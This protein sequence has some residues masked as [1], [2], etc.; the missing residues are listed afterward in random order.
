MAVKLKNNASSKLAGAIS[1]AATTITVVTGEGGKFPSL[2]AGDYFP[3]TLVKLVAGAPVYEIAYCTAIAGDV[4]TIAR[5]KEGTL[6]TTFSAG[7]A[8]ELRMTSGVFDEL[9]TSA[10]KDKIST[11]AAATGAVALNLT[12]T[13]VHDLTLTGNTTLSLTNLPALSNQQ[14][15][16]IVRVT[17]GATPYSITWFGGITWLTASGIAA[18]APGAN[19]TIEYVFTTKDGVAFLGRKGGAN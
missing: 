1:A 3:L 9:I 6:A 2:A 7:D 8:V 10:S 15:T 5:A 17:Q 19:K 14:C 18:A 12:D 13:Y 16:F 4:L 11:N